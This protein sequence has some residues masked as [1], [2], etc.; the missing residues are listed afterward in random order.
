MAWTTRDGF[1]LL[2]LATEKG[3]YEL[4]LRPDRPSVPQPIVVDPTNLERGFYSVVVAQSDLGAR[5]VAAA[6]RGMG[7]VYLSTEGGRSNTYRQTDLRGEDA[8]VLAVQYALGS[9]YLWAGTYAFGKEAGKG[10]YRLDISLAEGSPEGWHRF[11][12]GW[13]GGGVRSLAFMGS[14]V[15]AATDA[16]GVLTLS[17]GDKD[18][19]WQA[20]DFAK[21][22]LPIREESEL[23]SVDGVDADPGKRSI[24]A[25]GPQGVYLS[26]DQGASYSL[27]SRT[28]LEMVTLP[29]TWLFCSGEHEISVVSEDEASSH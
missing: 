15:L 16:A 24:L 21:C 2:L 3:L 5:S 10:C 22:K 20:P 25:A 17:T 19:A 4:L 7:G 1:P 8:R 6:A 13:K 23:D 14:M 28:N 27:L 9:V 18:P 26:S 11:G 29:K 12:Q